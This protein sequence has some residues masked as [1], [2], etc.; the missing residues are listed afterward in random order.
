[1]N[2]NAAVKTYHWDRHTYE[3][4]VEAGLFP[5]HS[6]AELINGEIVEMSPQ[7]TLHYTVL[8]LLENALRESFDKG[9]TVRN[10]AP[11]IVS[12][13]SEPEPDLAVVTGVPRDYLREHPRAALLLVEVSDSTL[14]YDRTVKAALYADCGVPEYWIAN[15]KEA[16]VE[17]FRN[18]VNGRYTEIRTHYTRS[19]ITPLH[20]KAAI[21]VAE[22]LP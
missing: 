7:G 5:P 13:D 12:D 10:Q 3:R 16:C 22:V 11:F 8:S 19:S 21:A 20:G 9:V 6:H 14:Q 4:M 17:V 1:M 18:P 2:A 15:L